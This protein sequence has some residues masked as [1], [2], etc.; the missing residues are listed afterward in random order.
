MFIL[1]YDE[2]YF[3]TLFFFINQYP[4][5]DILFTKYKKLLLYC[6]KC[7]EADWW[8]IEFSILRNENYI[9]YKFLL[10]KNLLLLFVIIIGF[11]A[12]VTFKTLMSKPNST[13]QNLKKAVRIM[14]AKVCTRYDIIFNGIQDTR[15]EII[16]IIILIQFCDR[17]NRKQSQEKYICYVVCCLKIDN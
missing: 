12:N 8:R 5:L 6:L 15:C 13:I 17:K 10:K 9:M 11:T 14:E 1:N 4:I 2:R 3:H 16:K 7:K